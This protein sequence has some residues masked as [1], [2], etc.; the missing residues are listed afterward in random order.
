[1][2]NP[3]PVMIGGGGEKVTLRLTAQYADIWNGFG[4]PQELAHKNRVLDDWCAKIGRDPKAVER[5]TLLMEKPENSVLDAMVEAGISHFILGQGTPF[6]TQ[7][8]EK[9]LEWRKG[10]S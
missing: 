3:I 8:L 5:S 2:R 1:V 9:L 7:S 4:T 6:A 10:R